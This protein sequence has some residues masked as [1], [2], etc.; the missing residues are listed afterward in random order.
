MR[1]VKLKLSALWVARMLSGLQGDSTRLHDPVALREL[2]EG[3]SSVQVTDGLLFI[4]SLIFA[5]P[6]LMVVLSLTLPDRANRRTNRG[7]G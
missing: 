5:I 4:M 2:V 7:L 6:I 3:T 1:D